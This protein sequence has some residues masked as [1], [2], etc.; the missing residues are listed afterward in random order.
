VRAERFPSR[1]EE[2]R[3]LL[4]EKPSA[5]S[6]QSCQRGSP[7]KRFLR[8]SRRIEQLIGDVLVIKITIPGAQ[9]Q[10]RTSWECLLTDCIQVFP[11]VVETLTYSG[12]F[13]RKE[14][15][16][17][18]LGLHAFKKKLRLRKSS[19]CASLPETF[20]HNLPHLLHLRIPK[21]AT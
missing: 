7:Q 6:K 20:P 19:I 13:S 12:I 18:L 1:L 17:F 3:V 16:L 14:A 15:V 10:P 5:V 11:S 21:S 8:G 2:E 4:M 9:Y